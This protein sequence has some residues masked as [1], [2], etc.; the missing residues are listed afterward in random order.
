ME[1]LEQTQEKSR[2]LGSHELLV[3]TPPQISGQELRSA[4]HQEFLSDKLMAVMLKSLG[5]V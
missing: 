4:V 3:A 1:P 5:R 2:V